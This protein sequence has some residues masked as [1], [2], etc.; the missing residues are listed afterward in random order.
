MFPILGTNAKRRSD[1]T[2]LL[3]Q[4]LLDLLLLL[5]TRF[6]RALPGWLWSLSSLDL[7]RILLLLVDLLD[8]ASILLAEAA[9]ALGGAGILLRVI[10]FRFLAVLLVLHLLVTF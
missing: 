9:V 10:F 8:P 1:R 6:R 3:W 7:T 5:R 2:R 4:R